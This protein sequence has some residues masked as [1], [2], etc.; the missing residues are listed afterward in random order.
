MDESAMRLTARVAPYLDAIKQ[1]RA[2]GWRWKDIKLALGF[3][4]SDHALA[5]AV[6]RCRWVAEQKPLPEPARPA[7]SVAKTTAVPEATKTVKA[8]EIPKKAEYRTG[9]EI[10]SQA[11]NFETLG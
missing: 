1:K 7:P 11:G 8:L 2:A 9:A 3:A 5:Q 6:K 4:C 10:I